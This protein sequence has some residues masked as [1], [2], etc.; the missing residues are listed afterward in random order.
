MMIDGGRSGLLDALGR[1]H[2]NLTRLG[3]APLI[4]MAAAE[5][6]EDESQLRRAVIIT[7]QQ[8]IDVTDR[9]RQL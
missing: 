4:D 2:A 3:V 9:L 8:L 5:V 1:L 7:G 6:F